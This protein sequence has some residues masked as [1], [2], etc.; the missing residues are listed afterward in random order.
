MR[1][2]VSDSSQVTIKFRRKLPSV[3]PWLVALTGDVALGDFISGKVNQKLSCYQ[4]FAYSR[5]VL[6]LTV[7]LTGGNLSLPISV[8]A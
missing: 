1:R 5:Q 4:L 6:T 3:K 2:G 8:G 7:P